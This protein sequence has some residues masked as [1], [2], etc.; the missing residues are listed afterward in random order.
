[1]C[2]EVEL[3]RELAREVFMKVLA[4]ISTATVFAS[5]ALA[6]PSGSGP[7]RH[8]FSISDTSYAARLQATVSGTPPY[9]GAPTGG[10][11]APR[12]T[13]VYMGGYYYPPALPMVM[14]AP[15]APPS[16]PQVIV[17]NFYTPDSAK[18]LAVEQGES[19]EVVSN[20]RVYSAPVQQPEAVQEPANQNRE[21][22][23]ATYL[24]V[25]K[26]NSIQSAMACWREGGMLHY[27]T[28][29]GDHKSVP[30]AALDEE[31]TVKLNRGRGLEFRLK[32]K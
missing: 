11:R 32:G 15:Y 28:V 29:Q 3:Y 19:E 23:P 13:P 24:V 17:N 1:M 12:A 4:V 26:D 27:V 20:V 14:F 16:S 2:S 6:Q 22:K 31:Y 30:M 5:A 9:T 18:P 7:S 8:P 21:V 10:G 25:F